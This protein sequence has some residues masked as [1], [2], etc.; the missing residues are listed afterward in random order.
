MQKIS[1]G[2]E[3]KVSNILINFL[4]L[5]LRF[6]NFL[7]AHLKHFPQNS[8]TKYQES[9]ELKRALNAIKMRNYRSNLTGDKRERY[10]ARERLRQAS[11]RNEK[12]E[13]LESVKE[14]NRYRQEKSRMLRVIPTSPTKFQKVVRAVCK[15]SRASPTKRQILNDTLAS[16]KMTLK[17]VPSTKPKLSILQLQMLRRQNRQTEHGELVAKIKK[18]YGSINKAS[19]SLHIPYKTLHNLCQPLLKKKKS[20]RET[21]VNIQKFYEKDAVSHHHPSARFNGRRFLITTLEDCYRLY[22]D[23]CREEC[24]QPV[25]FSTFAR[26]RPK[27]VFKIDQTPDRQCICDECENFRMTRRILNRLGVKGVPP[28][29]KDCIEMSMCDN[30]GDN[31]DD[32]HDGVTDSDAYH[33]IDPNYGR[34]ECINR[35]CKKCGKNLVLLKILNANSDLESNAAVHEY[36]QWVWVKKFPKAKTRQLVLQ[37][38][39]GT[40]LDIV[41]SFAKQLEDLAFH[42]FCCN[43]NYAQFQ[44]VRDNLKPGFVLQV[45]D[46]GQNFMNI[47]QDEPQAVHWDH[48][49]TT[50]HPIISYYIKPGESTITTEEHI[51]ISSDLNHDKYAVKKFQDLSLEH[52]KSK[53]VV[54]NY[55]VIFSDNCSRQ[56]KGK[57]TFQFHSESESPLLHMFFGARHGKGPADGAVGRIKNAAMRAIK[58]RQVVLKNAFDFYKFCVSKFK[59]TDGAFQ[60]KF[61]FVGEIDRKWKELTAHTT[62]GSSSWSGVRSTGTDMVLEVR[63]IACCCE[64]CLL[65]DGSSC[66]N[67]AYASQWSV[68]NLVTGKPLMD[69]TFK[70]EHW[71]SN[72]H[73]DSHDS[74]ADSHAQKRNHVRTSGMK[75]QEVAVPEVPLQEASTQWSEILNILGSFSTYSDLETYVLSLNEKYSKAVKCAVQKFRK[76]RHRV[77]IVAKKSMHTDSPANV[78]PVVTIGD[79]NC[80]PRSLSIAAFGDDSRQ[81]ELRAKI[82]LESVINKEKYLNQDYLAEGLSVVR[83]DVTLPEVYAMFSGQNAAGL[84]ENVIETVYEKEVM[85]ITKNG[86]YM[87]IWQLF[88]ATNV[89]GHPVRSV[90][91]LR[92]SEVFRRDFNRMCFPLDG[93]HKRTKPITVMWTPTVEHGHVHHFVPLVP[94]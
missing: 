57:G 3:K 77:D 69:P 18:E 7:I 59:N 79:G 48:N 49:Q 60:Q 50:I 73:A 54:P 45:Y 21:W 41:T 91:P 29:S 25:S 62:H 82:I 9:I 72:S 33:Q 78:V 44:H 90:F 39:S 5:V 46:F 56:Y 58:S 47:F 24:K 19:L 76:C 89:L 68:F 93:R 11:I 10:L 87:G 84:S 86:S 55:L 52:L 17:S 26:L 74:H 70:N 40:L 12:K 75:I 15:V 66:P 23:S 13:Q 80:C 67:K 16:F 85:G 36:S 35:S 28:H 64:S 81:L 92:G 37:Q 42:I 83:D 51:M 32:S 43:W 38:K 14:K 31:N 2:K 88:A 6:T 34:I 61:F 30:N 20:S 71:G 94:M 1:T 63:Q 8:E 27:N 65:G 22:K 53:G 4:F